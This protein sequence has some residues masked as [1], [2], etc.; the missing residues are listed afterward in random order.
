MQESR[1]G[2]PSSKTFWRFLNETEPSA[3]ASHWRYR[4]AFPPDP[5]VVAVGEDLKVLLTRRAMVADHQ[6]ERVESPPSA[7][8]SVVDTGADVFV[9]VPPSCRAQRRTIAYALDLAEQRSKAARSSGRPFRPPVHTLVLPSAIPLD[10]AAA[11]RGSALD[12]MVR[13]WPR[14]DADMR[15]T[16]R[17]GRHSSTCSRSP[18][19]EPSSVAR[20]CR[21]PSSRIRTSFPSVT[22][23]PELYSVRVVYMVKMH[24][25][26]LDLT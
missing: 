3:S 9:L 24:E 16:D 22:R 8:I 15:R 1:E 2:T 11:L 25:T 26:G 7:R 21:C 4:S 6:P 10:L 5:I 12:A 14:R 13:P 19:R 20:P 18:S 23:R 17:Q